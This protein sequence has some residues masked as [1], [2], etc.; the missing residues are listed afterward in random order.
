MKKLDS[1]KEKNVFPSYYKGP[2]FLLTY[3]RIER[4]G[5]YYLVS[6]KRFIIPEGIT[7]MDYQI[8]LLECY[9]ALTL[10]IIPEEISENIG[11]YEDI[12]TISEKERIKR[13]LI[14][15]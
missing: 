4:N 6:V 2:T 14:Q 10:F 15:K 5:K 1:I 3:V 8:F 9:N 13:T 11:I 7:N 12:Q